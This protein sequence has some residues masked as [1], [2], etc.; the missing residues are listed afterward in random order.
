MLKKSNETNCKPFCLDY[1]L[2]DF[3]DLFGLFD[4]FLKDK[5]YAC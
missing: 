5:Y 4:S 1:K 2:C 3:C